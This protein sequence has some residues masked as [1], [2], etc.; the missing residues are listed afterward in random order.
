MA[1]LKPPARKVD[2]DLT[3]GM[4]HWMAEC[5]LMKSGMLR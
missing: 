2:A 3:G 5:G 4:V 1:M